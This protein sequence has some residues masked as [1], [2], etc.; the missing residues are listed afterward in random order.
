MFYRDGC[1]PHRNSFNKFV[2]HASSFLR[3][4]GDCSDC[5]MRMPI[6]AQFGLWLLTM[7][8]NVLRLMCL[9][10]CFRHLAI[11]A[12]QLNADLAYL[13]QIGSTSA[14]SYYR[15][16]ACR[17]TLLPSPTCS[18]CTR[19]RAAS[20]SLLSPSEPLHPFV[21]VFYFHRSITLSP[22]PQWRNDLS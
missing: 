8:T 9:G 17:S 7:P 19:A 1:E 5:K 3:S 11:V 4:R 16:L 10:G 6:S 18:S 15:R 12:C 14:L 22:A 20:G 2:H 13:V 21:L